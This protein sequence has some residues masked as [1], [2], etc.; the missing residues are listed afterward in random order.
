MK[1]K[2]VIVLGIVAGILL[3]LYLGISGWK[4]N[5]ERLAANREKKRLK[6]IEDARIADSVDKLEKEVF[7]EFVLSPKVEQV[8]KNGDLQISFD[9]FRFT[10]EFIFDRYA[11]IY[12]SSWHYR[13]PERGNKYLVSVATITSGAKNPVL[14]GIYAYYVDSSGIF[15]ATDFKYEFYF[16]SDYGSYLGNYH[17]TGNDFAYTETIRFDLGAVVREEYLKYPILILASNDGR[18]SRNNKYLGN[19]PVE[20]TSTST[21]LTN[22][23]ALELS[24]NYKVIRILNQEKLIPLK[25]KLKSGKK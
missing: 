8:Y 17:E 14:P 13:Q 4:S 15:L 22:L 9:Q 3:V 20:Y 11:Q 12:S 21:A 7:R 25:E 19:P 2:L 6:D 16:W 23:S 5:Q 1:K 24:R 10:N 18:F